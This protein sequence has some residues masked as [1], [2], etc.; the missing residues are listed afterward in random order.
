[1]NG[2][3]K[4]GNLVVLS[5]TKYTSS[6]ITIYR[7]RENDADWVKLAR[8]TIAPFQDNRPLL[9]AG[10]VEMR[11]YTAVYMSNDDEVSQF[12]NEIAISCAP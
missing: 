3:D 12:S 2:I 4:T 10:K 7:R 9:Q 11:H 8:A 6:G 1:M 5:F